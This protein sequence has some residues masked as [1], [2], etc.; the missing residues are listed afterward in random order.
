MPFAN[1]SEVRVAIVPET[2]FAQTPATPSFQTLRLTSG[3]LRTNKT[4]VTSDERQADRNVRDEILTGLAAGG[5]YNFEF[6]ADTFDALLAGALR[7]AWSSNVLKNGVLRPSFTIEETLELGDNDSFSRFP[8]ATV[9]TMSLS[10]TAREKVTGSVAF[11]ARQEV[12]GSAPITGATYAAANT[13][14]VANASTNVA[15][16]T[17]GAISPAPRVRSLTFEINNGLR[18][19]PEVGSPYSNEYGA[20]RCNITGT[21]NAY[22]ESNDLY[23][24][25]LD[26]GTAALSLTIGA[27]ANKK[28]TLLFPKIRL[29]DG[30]RAVG[31]NSDDVMV[32]IPFRALLDPTEACSLKITRAVA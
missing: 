18:E 15:A 4:T 24:A 31:G 8:G 28:Y 5:S 32:N 16:L 25:V 20:D 1:G 23:Q 17:V 26:H 22:F 2:A 7:S 3:G 12:L 6:S 11:M 30:E 29:G 19:R 10:I 13:N 9:N 21:L 14:A 27:E